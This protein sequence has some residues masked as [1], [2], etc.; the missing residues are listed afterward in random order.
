MITTIN[1]AQKLKV[2]KSKVISYLVVP[3]GSKVAQDEVVARK[4]G[5]FSKIEITAPIS[6]VIE[7]INENG[8]LVITL[9]NDE[10]IPQVKKVEAESVVKITHTPKKFKNSIKAVFGTGNC[11][12]KLVFIDGEL[13]F[14]KLDSESCDVIIASQTLDSVTTFYKAS[15]IGVKGIVVT[16]L[17]PGFLEK[18]DKTVLQTGHMAL[19]VLDKMANPELTKKIAKLDSSNVAIDGNIPALGIL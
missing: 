5:L 17:K 12:G 11:E 6:G 19:L 2:S 18:I 15:A 13:E 14:T 16:W 1:L 7:S 3:I 8:E 4:N 10:S 9:I